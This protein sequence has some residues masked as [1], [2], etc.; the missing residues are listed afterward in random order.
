MPIFLFFQKLFGLHVYMHVL[1][2][3]A[4]VA[5]DNGYSVKFIVILTL[6]YVFTATLF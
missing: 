1:Y 5:V 6:P 3:S 2:W 4:P